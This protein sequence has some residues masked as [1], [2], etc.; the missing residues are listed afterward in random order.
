MIQ[1][2]P[3]RIAQARELSGLTKSELA[4]AVAVSVSA[5]AQWESGAKSPTPE[6]LAAVA[7]Q[8]DIPMA[9]LLKPL[10]TELQRKGPVTFR[11]WTKASTRK[12]GRKATRLAELVAEIFLWLTEKVALPDPVLPESDEVGP[13]VDV[14]RAAMN[15]RRAWGL[16]DRPLLKLGELLESKGLFINPASFADNRFDAFS[17]II[18]GRPFVFLGQDK[19]DRARARFDAAHELGHLLLHQHLTEADLAKPEVHKWVESQANGFASAFLLPE[20]TFSRDVL[21]STLSGFLKLKPKWG[22]SVQCMVVRAHDLGLITDSHYKELFRQIGLKRWRRSQGEPLDDLVPA[23]S[24]SFGKK[25]LAILEEAGLVR[26]WETSSLLQLP[27]PVICSVFQMS[28]EDLEPAAPKLRNVI[29]LDF[30]AAS[31]RPD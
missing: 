16:G 2:Y 25:S 27:L 13:T 30:R 5:V 15:T 3:E 4:E 8:L 23:I 6:N 26:S 1:T 31:R 29:P 17:C 18:N 7:D 19:G 14:E 20:T 10:P 21:D 24:G 9:M 12:A 28:A 11:A 22:V